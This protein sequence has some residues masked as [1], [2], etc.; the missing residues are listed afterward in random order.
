MVVYIAFIVAIAFLT[1][2]NNKLQT[3]NRT[4]EI[5]KGKLPENI[6]FIAEMKGTK[7]LVTYRDSKNNVIHK[8]YYVPRE[9]GVKFTK[10]IDLKAYEPNKG[11]TGQTS[12]GTQI[13]TTFQQ[14]NMNP[15]NELLKRLGIVKK[16]CDNCIEPEIDYYGFTFKP[17]I[18]GVYDNHDSNKP[19]N[20][21]ID[22]KLFY[23]SRASMG[24]GS[25]LYSPN[26]FL[27]YHIDQFIPFI[28]VENAEIVIM[29]EKPYNDFGKNMLG[30]GIRSNL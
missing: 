27:S 23:L 1:W 15:L 10:Y 11:F 30:I 24:I 20:V 6:E 19:V 7:F 14:P 18:F 4:L 29:L 8:E 22:V 28:S 2:K 13:E 9:G 26:V 25:T 16:P 12:S 5:E 17:G 3:A 21:G